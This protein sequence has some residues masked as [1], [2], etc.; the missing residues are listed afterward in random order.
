MS[1]SVVVQRAAHAPSHAPSH[2]PGHAPTRGAAHVPAHAPTRVPTYTPPR[3]PVPALRNARADSPAIATHPQ[4]DELRRHLQQCK[5]QQTMA[6]RMAGAMERLHG[7]LA[8]R[9]VTT[10]TTASALMLVLLMWI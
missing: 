6:F 2:V 7:V 9:F 8:P 5:A 3:G 10:A 4:E 1:A